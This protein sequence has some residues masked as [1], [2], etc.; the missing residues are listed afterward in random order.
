MQANKKKLPTSQDPGV[1]YS[2]RP[3]FHIGSIVLVGCEQLSFVPHVVS[4]FH[5]TQKPVQINDCPANITIDR[6][7]AY[8]HK[9]I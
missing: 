9:F 6:V 8:F 5:Q 2:R 7:S 1:Q 3:L 4:I